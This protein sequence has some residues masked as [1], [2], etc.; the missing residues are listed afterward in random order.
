MLQK[1]IKPGN[2]LFAFGIPTSKEDFYSDLQKENKDYAKLVARICKKTKKDPWQKYKKDI[3]EVIQ[4]V[5]PVMKDVGVTVIHQ[6]S[7]NAFGEILQDNKF[8]VVILLTHL[9]KEP[10]CSCFT[11]EGYISF[12]EKYPDFMENIV[13]SVEVLDW[14]CRN[15]KSLSFRAKTKLVTQRK[16]GEKH[17]V[18]FKN[19]LVHVKYDDVV[20][21][22][23]KNMKCET[24][25]QLLKRTN[26]SKIEF[27]EGLRDIYDVT[28]QIPPHYNRLIDLNS[29]MPEDFAVVLRKCR[30]HCHV[31]YKFDTENPYRHQGLIPRYMLFFYKTLFTYIPRKN[32]TYLQAFEQVAAEYLR[33][34]K[35]K[36]GY[37]EKI[38]SYFPK[39]SKKHW[40]TSR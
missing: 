13:H 24:F 39:L 33:Q 18:E 14:L 19:D 7:L 25:Y 29:C 40:R 8:D 2:C 35:K 16:W 27:H 3:I 37:I 34:G 31:R 11:K 32:L 21:D 22:H 1:V 12:L 9:K 38:K 17:Y 28:M 23:L 4:E 26:T 5:E 36:G 15:S 6:L 20:Y 10:N 30:P